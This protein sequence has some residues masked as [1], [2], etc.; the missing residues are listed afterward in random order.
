M[1]NFIGEGKHHLKFTENRYINV[2]KKPES[3]KVV[4]LVAAL[5][6]DSTMQT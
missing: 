2:T 3:Y 1:C 5:F 6:S 4:N